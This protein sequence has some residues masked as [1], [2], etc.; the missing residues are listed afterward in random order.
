MH[1]RTVVA[2]ALAALVATSGCLGILGGDDLSFS[3][4][5]ATVSEDALEQTG[6]QESSVESSEV[7]REFSVAGQSRNVTVTNWVAMYERTVSVPVVGEQR[8]AVFGA[9]ASPQVSV[10]GESFNPIED[11][12]NRR[13]AEL[14]QQQYEGLSVGD[15]VGNRTVTVLEES[16]TV[17]EFEGTARLQGQ[18]VDV[19]IHVTRVKHDGDFVV[20]LAIHPQQLDG[21]RERIDELLRGLE[22]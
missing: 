6:Y 4:S 21:E 20:A 10:L 17:E 22:H 12:S 9:F 1:R 15:S 8:A 5:Q 16:T 3:A 7:T 19:Y 14:A 2:V 18:S 13:L 11:Y